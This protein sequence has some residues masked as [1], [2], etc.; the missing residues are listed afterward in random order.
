VNRALW[1]LRYSLNGDN[2]APR[3]QGGGGGGSGREATGPLVVPGLYTV[4]LTAGDVTQERTVRV[5]E[6]PRFQ[7]DPG[8]RAQWTAELGA[9]TATLLEAQRVAREVQA[10]ARR[11]DDGEARATADV[12]TK[13]RDLDREMDELVSRLAR[14]RGGAEDWVGPLTADQASQKAFLTGLL[15][16]LTGEWQAVRGRVS[17]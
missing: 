2:D 11:L 5:E 16:T 9:L 17:N 12:T 7:V 10:A 14:L 4:R 8:V 15:E 3:G 6:D 1:N 13:V